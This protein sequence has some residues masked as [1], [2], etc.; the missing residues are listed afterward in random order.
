MENGHLHDDK[1]F[2]AVHDRLSDYEAPAN[3]ADWDA[4]SRSL[5]SLPKNSR[6]SWKISLNSILLLVGVVGISALSYAVVTHSGKN[7]SENK[8]N[9]QITIAQPQT[10]TTQP[11]V[12]P[13]PV[14]PVSNPQPANVDPNAF[15]NSN[16]LGFSNPTNG[17]VTQNENSQ[18]TASSTSDRN[19]LTNADGTTKT[20]RKNKNQLLFG[21]QV[22]P[23]KGFIYNTQEKH[24]VLTQPVTDPIPGIFYDKDVN[25]QTKK[26]EIKKDST[27]K[28]SS[29]PKADST[30][31]SSK[32]G[33]PTEGDQQGFDTEGN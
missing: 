5:D 27:S 14:V 9:S 3:G 20:K 32:P 8:T 18:T 23:K 1:L 16:G 11:K 30:A 25:G 19:S 4:M 15:A 7:S 13:N 22:D 2:R 26:I 17:I 29:K 33:A 12:N 21:D 6:F 31:K 24:E 10:E 28:G